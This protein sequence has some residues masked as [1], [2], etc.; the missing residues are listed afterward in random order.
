MILDTT[1]GDIQY[2]VLNTNGGTDQ[3]IPVPLSM[4]QWDNSSQGFAL[5]TD[6]TMLQNA[7][8]F[9]SDAFPDTTMSGWNSEFDSYW[10]NGGSG[11]TG[12]GLS[13]TETPTP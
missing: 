8:S 10:Q 7:P 12:T 11:G 1:T 3:L 6:S 4:F 5:N 13:A 9:S 2:I